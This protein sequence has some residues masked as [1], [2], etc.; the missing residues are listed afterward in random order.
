LGKLWQVVLKVLTPLAGKRAAS[1]G[2]QDGR[3]PPEGPAL[4]DVAGTALLGEEGPRPPGGWLRPGAQWVFRIAR[5]KMILVFL[6]GGLGTIAR[7]LVG[8]W[9]NEQPWGQ[10]FPWGTF[11][12]N[13]SGSFILGAA[14][15]VLLERLPP[16]Y[17]QWYLLIGTGLCGGYTTFSTFEWETYRLIRDGSWW[18]A[19][20]N[21][22]GS[23][24]A[25]FVGILLGVALVGV[26]F[27]KR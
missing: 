17:Q 18:Y 16:D 12:I 5:H 20:A 19:L 9:F 21:V 4:V 10:A 15:V 11:A 26:V 24:L 7:Y 27:P 14:A 23:V 22:L 3:S 1:D 2:F 8:K 6:G 13:V 25:G